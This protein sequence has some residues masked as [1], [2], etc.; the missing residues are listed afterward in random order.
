MPMEGYQGLASMA[1]I[2]AHLWALG[3][4]GYTAIAVASHCSPRLEAWL[5]SMRATMWA[6]L[7]G[8][9]AAVV[10]LLPYYLSERAL[11]GAGLLA[12]GTLSVSRGGARRVGGGGALLLVA[13]V[14][15]KIMAGRKAPSGNPPP[16]PP[17]EM[18]VADWLVSKDLQACAGVL[19]GLGYDQGVD[20][21]MDS[22]GVRTPP[23]T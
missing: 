3:T 12:D 4:F 17:P 22:D 21:L 2:E 20:M 15:R 1:A 7:F 19:A 18:R 10:S 8:S 9:V 13:L 14:V 11:P 23:T 6:E 5:E 16:P